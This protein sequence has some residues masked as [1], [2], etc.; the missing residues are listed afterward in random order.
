MSK[1][2]GKISKIIDHL[3]LGN[4]QGAVDHDLLSRL[5]IKA[6]VTIGCSPPTHENMAY[7]K[8]GLLDHDNSNVLI[9]MDQVGDFIHSYISKGD[10]VFVHCQAGMNRSP[11]FVIGYLIKHKNNTFQ[12]AYDIVKKKRPIIRIRES[13]ITQLETY[14]INNII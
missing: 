5:N 6:V 2:S 3:Y 4:R 14:Q 9:Y 8:I 11:T 1:K 13:Y 7:L 10:N 12:S